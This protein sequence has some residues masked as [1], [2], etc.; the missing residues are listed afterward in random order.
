MRRSLI[1][2]IV[3]F[4]AGI[5][6]LA[7]WF[8]LGGIKPNVVLAVAVT[9]SLFARDMFRLSVILVASMLILR[10]GGSDLGAVFIFSGLMCAAFLARTWTP[11]KPFVSTMLF[12]AVITPVFYALFDWGFLEHSFGVVLQET[13]YNALVGAICFGVFSRFATDRYETDFR[14]SF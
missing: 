9:W 3:F 14:A 12:I 5:L 8:S 10:A 4:G 11:G 7:P 2:L 1:L 6:Q 13:V